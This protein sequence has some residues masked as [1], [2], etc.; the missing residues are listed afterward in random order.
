ML[1]QVGNIFY[2]FS[3]EKGAWAVLE[4]PQEAKEKPRASTTTEHILVQQGKRLYAFSLNQGKWS[5][6]VE[7]DLPVKSK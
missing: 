3:A 1:Y 7:M 2:A 4:L 6:P 5:M